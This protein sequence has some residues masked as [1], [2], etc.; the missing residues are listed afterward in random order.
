MLGIRLRWSPNN[1]LEMLYKSK[2]LHLYNTL[3]TAFLR[4]VHCAYQCLHLD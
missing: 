4:T 2:T 1:V 3:F